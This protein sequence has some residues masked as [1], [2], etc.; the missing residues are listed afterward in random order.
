MKADAIAALTAFRDVKEQV[1]ASRNPDRQLLQQAQLAGLY[2]ICRVLLSGIA[3]RTGRR[4]RLEK[5][6]ENGD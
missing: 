1:V 2:A 5:E 3:A 6:V 4:R